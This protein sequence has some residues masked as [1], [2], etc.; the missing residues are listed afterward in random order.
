MGKAIGEAVRLYFGKI[1]LPKRPEKGTTARYVTSQEPSLESHYETAAE[2]ILERLLDEVQRGLAPR[3]DLNRAVETKAG[4]ALA[5]SGALLALSAG[6]KGA[7]LFTFVGGWVGLALA[8]IAIIAAFYTSSSLRPKYEPYALSYLDAASLND[9]S[10]RVQVWAD[11]VNRWDRF[12]TEV[13]EIHRVRA[14][15]LRVAFALATAAA[16]V[17]LISAVYASTRH[18][19]AVSTSAAP[20][21]PSRTLRNK[22]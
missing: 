14:V 1:T 13:G 19:I 11:L 6:F 3:R 15:R 2:S 12:S 10:K 18:G 21:G 22:P 9:D 17:L 16:T 8:L 20:C 5:F 7:V 4:A